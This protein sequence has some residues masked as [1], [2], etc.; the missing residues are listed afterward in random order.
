MQLRLR[1]LCSVARSRESAQ[2][3]VLFVVFIMVLLVLAG[4]AYDYASIV[5]DD[6]KLQNAVDASALAG[7]DALTSNQT[8]PAQTAVALAIATTNSYLSDNQVTS[9]NST[10]Q[11]TPVPWVPGAGTPTPVA[12]VYTG[13]SVDVTRNHPTAFWPLVGVPQ[14]TMHNAGSAQGA[15]SMLDVMLSM[16]TTGSLVVTGDLTDTTQGVTGT[17]LINA[18]LGFV[19]QLNPTTSDPL[20]PKIGIAR[21][22][23]IKCSWKD[24]DS[25]GYIDVY[26][27]GSH[28]NEYTKSYSGTSCTDD[29]TVLS[30]LTL[31]QTNLNNI[32]NGTAGACP[33]G[34]P[35]TEACP[36]Q[37]HPYILGTATYHNGSSTQNSSNFPY[38][39]GTKEP[40]AICAVM[41]NDALSPEIPNAISTNGFA[42]STAN[43]ARNGSGNAQARR[44]LVIMTDGQ[45]EAWPSTGVAPNQTDYAFPESPASNYDS[46]FQTLANHLKASNPD[47]NGGPGVE[48]YVVGYFCTDGGS[49]Q[50]NTYPPNNFC[51]SQIAY[52]ASPRACPGPPGAAIPP[53]SQLSA[54]DQML[55][56]V[57]SSSP[58]TCDHYIPLSK[59]DKTLPTVFTQLAGTISRGRLTQ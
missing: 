55:I 37:H 2:I 39:T 1:R 3:M 15:R 46:T 11:V 7:A 5:V 17:Q 18:I 45:D 26:L 43:G 41:P 20:G 33:S 44:V 10:I 16:D 23:G 25:D 59:A 35:T 52:T 34:V 28:P 58:G 24:L 9:S 8:L 14:V 42:W 47:G 27:D 30:N 40:N 31:N 54:V 22:A 50:S 6:A 49:F 38:Y 36:L 29:A 56:N 13:I 32:A 57:S 12:T 21:Y 51:Q 4:S 53:S 48:I 19:Q